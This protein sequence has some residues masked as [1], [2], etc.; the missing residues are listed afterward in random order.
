MSTST[1]DAHYRALERRYKLTEVPR[2]GPLMV[3]N[4]NADRPVHR[5]F[6]LKEGY[7]SD[8]LAHVLRVTGLEDQ[9]ELSLL[10][11]FVGGGT[12]VLSGA[13]WARAETGRSVHAIGVER[14]PFLAFLARTKAEAASGA[15]A[16]VAA[17]PRL[18]PG[19][20][21]VPALSTF[22]NR[23]YFDPKQLQELLKL[24]R[25]ILA[26]RDGL[27]RRLRLLALISCVEPVSRLRRDGRTMRRAGDKPHARPRPE[28]RKR[29]DRIR[30]DLEALTPRN[31]SAIDLRV[32]HGDSRELSASL[33]DGFQA[34]LILCSPP[35][36]NNIDYT[37]VYK[38][39]AWFMGAYGTSQAFREQRHL[40]LR[41]HPSVKFEATPKLDDALLTKHLATL[42]KPLLAALP[43]DRYVRPRERLVRGYVEDMALTLK[44]CIGQ[45]RVGGWMAVVVGNSLHGSGEPSLLLAADLLIAR[46][47][48]LVGWEVVRI[49][50]GRRP[51]R[52]SGIEPRLR[53]SMVLLR[54]PG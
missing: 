18:S 1:P 35:Y 51:A 52:R 39:E 26:E 23:D 19:P 36:P 24:R 10:D 28:L 37:E 4:G 38:L 2:L 15:G 43:H 7:S 40:T 34:D 50:V 46:A 8:L 41:S 32:H 29:L 3:P 21:L 53:E 45:T 49:D 42:V 47:A 31:G 9:A 6:H 13:E 25:S 33:P 30:E 44:Q 11:P 12:T 22:T 17:M 14:N 5:W 54:R 27:A 48:E 16:V 20:A